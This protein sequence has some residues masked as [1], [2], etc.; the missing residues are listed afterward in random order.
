MTNALRPPAAYAGD[1]GSQAAANPGDIAERFFALTP[2]RVL[3]AVETLGQRSTGYALALGSLENRVY[4]VELEDG[5]RVVAKFYRPGRWSREAI[6]EEHALCAELVEAEVP[7]VAPLPVASGTL[8]ELALAEPGDAAAAAG[9]A[10]AG[11]SILFTVFPKVRGRPP[12]ELTGDQLEWLGRLLARLHTVGS[13][14][15]APSR[16][17]LDATSY[18]AASLV[19]LRGGDWI[20]DAQ[21]TPYFAVAERLVEACGRALERWGSA[22]PIRLHGDCHLGN[23]LWGSAG[24]FFLDFDDF[25]AGPPAQDLWLI[26]PGHD[27]EALGQRDRIVRGYQT[28]RD[29]D[30]DG[31]MLVEPLRALR[32]LRYA[33]W[34]AQRWRDPSFQRAFPGFTEAAFWQREISALDQQLPRVL[35]SLNA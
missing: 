21:A 30:E 35:A 6:E 26:A 3:D 17:T 20:P 15:A 16:G 5:T 23:L 1:S 33:A 31:L 7:V 27:E 10:R 22:P 28:M 12:E 34:I 8:G 9:G 11:S 24:P 18:G 19:L 13:R 32:I 4:E 14:R 29:F 25:L 2:E